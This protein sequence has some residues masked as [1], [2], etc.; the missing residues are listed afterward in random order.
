MQRLPKDVGERIRVFVSDSSPMG[1]Q[2]LSA[3]LKKSN[4]RFVLAGSGVNSHAILSELAEHKPH[5]A[6]VSVQLE[7][8]ALAG[9]TVVREAHRSFPKTRCIMLLDSSE[10][11]MVVNAFRAGAKGVFSKKG[12]L[13]ALCKC[14]YAVHKGQIW[15]TADELQC[16]LELLTRAAP[17][18]MLDLKGAERLTKREQQVVGLIAQGLTNTEIARELS[19]SPHTIKNYIFRIFEK[20]GFSS[21]VELVIYAMDRQHRNQPP[22]Q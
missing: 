6:L 13:D 22:K 15:A 9:F 12:S 4:H 20:M 3:A 19:L 16:V 2:L 14:I 21:R 18:Q 5:I 1:C 10:A 11:E 7:D 17:I 8:G